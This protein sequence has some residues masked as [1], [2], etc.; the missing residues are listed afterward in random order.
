MTERRPASVDSRLERVLVVGAGL[1]GTSV[2]LAL[3]ATGVEVHLVDHDLAALALAVD[4]GAGTDRPPIGDPDVVVLAVP[5]AAV[6]RVLADVQRLYPSSTFTD[7]SSVKSRPQAEAESLGLDLTRYVGG[8]PMAGRERTGAGAA[9]ADLFEGRPWVLTPGPTTSPAALRLVEELVRRCRADLVVMSPERHDRAV[10]LVSHAPQVLAS[11]MAARLEPSDP[12]L[13]ALAGQGLRDVTRI[14]AS[15]PALWTE[16]LTANAPFV[17]AVLDGVAADLA[18]VRAALAA[19]DT[20]EGAAAVAALLARGNAGRAR[21]PGKHG[22]PA[23]T[24]TA[25]PV[26]LPDRPGELARI[27]DAAGDAGINVED[28]SIEHSPGQ[29]VGLVELSVRPEA[30]T[31]LA[32][33]LRRRGWAVHL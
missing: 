31:A 12:D 22:A 9:R 32:E 27:F 17:S 13:V 5:P 10:A 19:A 16:I 30:A 29:P 20:A 3:T 2:A 1:M 18:E 11:L 7:L 26:V 25:V 14:A 24:Y 15:D 33:A 28:V 6:A 21:L 23:A 8:H 4:L